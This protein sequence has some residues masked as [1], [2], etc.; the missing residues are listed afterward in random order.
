MYRSFI[1][2]PNTG[3]RRP[4]TQPDT[5]DRL[6][7]AALTE[8]LTRAMGMLREDIPSAH[9]KSVP[10]PFPYVKYIHFRI[11]YPGTVCISI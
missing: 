1:P 11:V 2:K 9:P 3:Q 10:D 5:R 6:V 4:I 8:L 7:S